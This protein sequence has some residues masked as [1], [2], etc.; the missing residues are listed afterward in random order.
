LTPYQYKWWV[1][2][3]IDWAVVQ[4]WSTSNTFVWTPTTANA[5]YRVSVW[6]RN[7]RY[8]RGHVREQRESEHLVPISPLPPAPPLLLTAINADLTSPQR[9][10]PP[11]HSAQSP[12]AGRGIISTNGGS[13]M[14]LRGRSPRGG[15]IAMR[16]RGHRAHRVRTIASRSGFA[17]RRVPAIRTTTLVER[18]HRLRDSVA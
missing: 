15:V 1:F 4:P 10:E 3:G 6:V 16:S 17:R 7:A 8:H 9:P 2:D 18:Q 13:S 12:R 11:S 5:G 14:E